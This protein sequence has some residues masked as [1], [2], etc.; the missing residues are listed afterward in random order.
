MMW[1]G[2]GL[3]RKPFGGLLK[4]RHLKTR[5]N[6]FGHANIVHHSGLHQKFSHVFDFIIVSLSLFLSL[7]G[8]SNGRQ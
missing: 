1:S 4:I 2:T 3:E 8:I 6:M 7:L 5:R